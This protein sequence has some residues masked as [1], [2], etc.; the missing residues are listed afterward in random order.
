MNKTN[1]RKPSST[2]ITPSKLLKK[3]RLTQNTYDEAEM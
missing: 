2:K 1:F 3:Q